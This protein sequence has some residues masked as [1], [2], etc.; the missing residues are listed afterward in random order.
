MLCFEVVILHNILS[1]MQNQGLKFNILFYF[2]T[3][4][5]LSFWNVKHV[6]N[7]IPRWTHKIIWT[8]NMML[9]KCYVRNSVVFFF[10]LY[11]S[12]VYFYLVDPKSDTRRIVL[13]HWKLFIWL[14]SP[15]CA[16]VCTIVYGI[17]VAHLLAGSCLQP[18][19]MIRKTFFLW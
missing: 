18:I 16:T 6:V 1:Y 4:I 2:I 13:M 3:Y 12:R 19:N 7:I 9:L 10:F 14:F 8:K 15:L 17:F 5:A 11:V